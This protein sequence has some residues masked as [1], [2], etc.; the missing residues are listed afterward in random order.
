MKLF[1]QP[2]QDLLVR[3]DA[4]PQSCL[5]IWIG[6]AGSEMSGDCVTDELRCR[7]A[8]NTSDEFDLVGLV[9]GLA[10]GGDPGVSHGQ[11]LPS[12]VRAM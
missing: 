5:E 10:D 11:V 7:D 12:G 1:R 6:S 8:V 9:G 2:A 4:V 3:L